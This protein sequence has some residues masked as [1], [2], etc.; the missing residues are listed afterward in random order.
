MCGSQ[1]SYIRGTNGNSNGIVPMLRVFND[2]CVLRCPAIFT[3]PGFTHVLSSCHGLVAD[4][5]QR[6]SITAAP[7][8]DEH[9]YCH[10]SMK[11]CTPWSISGMRP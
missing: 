4:V 1:G 10:Y 11:R 5:W 3:L 6:K 9:V 8:A 2:T 7:G